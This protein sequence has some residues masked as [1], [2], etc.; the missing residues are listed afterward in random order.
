MVPAS[1]QP[2][3]ACPRP[4]QRRVALAWALL[5]GVLGVLCTVAAYCWVALQTPAHMAYVMATLGGSTSVLLALVT[6]GVL[7]LRQRDGVR[8]DLMASELELMSRVARYSNN[9]VLV[10]DVDG[11]ITWVNDAFSH[12]MGY[13]A[14]EAVGR[15][16]VPLLRSPDTDPAIQARTD[17]A[18]R[19]RTSLEQEGLVR[20]KDGTDHWVQV[21]WQPVYTPRGFFIGY[22]VVFTNIERRY[23]AYQ[24]L[25]Q[26]LDQ[27]RTLIDTLNQIAIVSEADAAG[28]ITRVNDKFLHVSGYTE[29]EVLG[30]NY[31][32]F[33][34]GVHPPAFWADFWHT[35][36]QGQPWRGEICNRT[37]DGRLYWLDSLIA[38]L[39][40]AQGRLSGYLAIRTDI[41][42]HKLAQQ[43]LVASQHMLARTG[44]IAGVGGWFID[45]RHQRLYLSPECLDI[46]GVEPDVDVGVETVL[47]YCVPKFN[48][49]LHTVFAGIWHI[50]EPFDTT[51]NVR[52]PNGLQRSVRLVGEPDTSPDQPPRL[53]GAAQDVTSLVAAQRRIQESERTLLSAIDALGEA[54]ALYDPQERLV[55]CNE[56]FLQTYPAA[57]EFLWPGV[58]YED[59]LRHIA[60]QGAYANAIGRVNEWVAE[61]LQRFRANESE[62]IERLSDGRWLRMADCTTPDGFHVTFR[63]DITDMQR[64]LEAADAASRSKSQFLANMSHEIRTPMNAIIG[65]LR[66]LGYTDLNAQQTDWVDKA[67]H[68]ATSLLGIL[69]D[70]LDFSKVEAGKMQLDPAPLD[71][72]GL[73]RDMS[74]L[75]ASTLGHKE[76][77]LV[78]DLDPAMP[79][80]LVA[81]GLRLKQ[82]LINLCGNAIKFTQRGAVVL[83]VRVLQ[84]STDTVRWRLE[85]QDSGIGITPEQQQRI[86]N[87][88]TQAEAS[89]ARQFGGTGLGLAISQ[90]L[91]RLMGGEL[92]LDS[93]PGQGSTFWCE[94]TSP[95]PATEALPDASVAAPL[96]RSSVRSVLLVEGHALTRH[97]LANML[98]GVGWQVQPV[99]SAAEALAWLPQ[100]LGQGGALD[101]VLLDAQLPDMA[102][103]ALRQRCVQQ[104]HTHAPQR[105]LPVCVVLST[106]HLEALP[107]SDCQ[108]VVLV[109][110]V[111]AAMVR[112][113]VVQQR[114]GA[115]ARAAAAP[116]QRLAGLRLLLVEDNPMNQEVAQEML[117]REGASVDGVD[118]GERALA[119]LSHPHHGY[120]LVLMDMQM[121]VMD[122]VQATRQLRQR[123]EHQTLPIVAMTANAMT[124]DRE[125]CLQA[126]MNDHVGKPFE[127]D[128]LVQVIL[129][130]TRP[131]R[132]APADPL[133][134]PPVAQAAPVV[135]NPD[136]AIARLGGDCTFFADVLQ[137]FGLQAQATVDELA[138]AVA[139]DLRPA[140]RAAAH[141]FKSVAATAGA[142]QLAAASAALE[143]CMAAT[144]S[145]P[146]AEVQALLERLHTTLDEALAAQ[147]E[148]LHHHHAS[149]ACIPVLAAPAAPVQQALQTLR[150]ALQASD[151][152]VFELHDTLL[153]QHGHPH[154]ERF[155][156]LNR[157]MATLDTAAALDAIDALLTP[158]SGAEKVQNP[159]T[160]V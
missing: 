8:S 71:L 118:N 117:R 112:D 93:R 82:V 143:R 125:V 85:V 5:V 153:A 87:G 159:G 97:T 147:T 68:A 63:I 84:R 122:G 110:P 47:G 20:Y 79:P 131:A 9:A 133:P 81:D 25:Q 154:P 89:T 95:C 30:H 105:P 102:L 73:W 76:L 44:R 94:L 70:I 31:R 150:A 108:A 146:A 126:G 3:P 140:A 96:N 53:V 57:S 6:W 123:P 124:A 34:A 98:H 49:A 64:A 121:P 144:E 120:D 139:H 132:S 7:W 142:E 130:H 136:T 50:Q 116:S 103:D 80:M 52:L 13:S 23:H 10:A 33:N 152:N 12:Q 151:L 32:L 37:K 1:S 19:D 104:W 75:L 109:K 134:P 156:A 114:Q 24:A 155:A 21:N 77:E 56:K 100:H 148:W 27:N 141:K 99:A 22:V 101:A 11:V 2:N 40:G 69:N 43:A 38:P 61:R 88:F 157:A 48:D 74:T 46:L 127:L 145:A 14:A 17:A 39:Y 90:R 129:H 41:T 138:Q 158:F 78:F 65:M 92:G 91:V 28:R 58:R 62:H 160:L 54:F 83:R 45:M 111:T 26:T 135:F 55:F 86:F 128:V 137:R 60:E 35:L 51:V 106:H 16:M 18:L 72:E 59:V 42:S 113:A 149:C 67:S 115:P 29:A 36:R 4:Q 15:A 119:V 107:P 66:L